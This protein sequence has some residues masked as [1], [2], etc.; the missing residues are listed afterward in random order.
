MQIFLFYFNNCCH[1]II[2]AVDASI[3]K[4]HC[5][6]VLDEKVDVLDENFHPPCDIPI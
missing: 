4:G 6:V 2:F 3:L 5:A 1:L